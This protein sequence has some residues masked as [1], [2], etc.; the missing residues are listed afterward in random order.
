VAFELLPYLRAILLFFTVALI[1]LCV[2]VS[3][4]SGEVHQLNAL[5][6]YAREGDTLVIHS[7][8]RLARNIDDLRR[9]VLNETRRGVRIQFK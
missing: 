9:I 6:S 1:L 8:D 7:M 5:L 3:A 4:K 2:P